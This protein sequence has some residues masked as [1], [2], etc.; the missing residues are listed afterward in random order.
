MS[1]LD[2]QNIALRVREEVGPDAIRS[3]DADAPQPGFTVD[4]DHM[5]E[6]A[7]VL[8]D[9][10][11]FSR[12]L[13]VAGIDH[14]GYDE[15]GK[16]KHRKI[17]QYAEDGSVEAVTDPATGDL[18]VVYHLH[19]ID[20]KHLLTLRVRMPRDDARVASVSTVWPT[21]L[22]GERETFDMYGIEFT[23]HPDL[24]RLLLPEDWVGHPLRKDYEMP[25][26]Y[27]DVPLEGLPLAV[28]AEAENAAGP[29]TNGGDP[30]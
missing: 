20:T 29:T 3:I 25:A 11:G 22:W 2:L 1:A 13:N 17:A 6:V 27:H 19:N 7:L 28:R 10:C 30:A 9:A 14:E 4:P 18:G 16:G 8:R 15:T 26:R 23:G 5:T 24:R 21:A 12:L